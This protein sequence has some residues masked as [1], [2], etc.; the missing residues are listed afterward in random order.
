MAAT[1]RHGL[2]SL[3]SGDKPL[4]SCHDL[5]IVYCVNPEESGG[6][7][8]FK[9]IM[10]SLLYLVSTQLFISVKLFRWRMTAKICVSGFYALHCLI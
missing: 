2:F 3:F 6:R 7:A 1:S 4:L 9:Q 5:N 10:V 8:L